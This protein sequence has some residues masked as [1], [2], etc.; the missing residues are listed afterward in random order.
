MT[1]VWLGWASSTNHLQASNV[2]SKSYHSHRPAL[3]AGPFQLK[4]KKK[5]PRLTHLPHNHPI[6]APAAND[7]W[8]SN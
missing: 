4:T 5:N 8:W 6:F 1:S 3:D 2:Q 7:G